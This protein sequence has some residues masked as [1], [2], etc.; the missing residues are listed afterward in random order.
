M[1]D[2]LT[3]HY[4]SLLGR[5]KKNKKKT[6]LINFWVNA[7]MNSITT[8]EQLPFAEHYVLDKEETLADVR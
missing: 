3:A 5:R 6:F 7:F 2:V 4:K 8:Y 1:V